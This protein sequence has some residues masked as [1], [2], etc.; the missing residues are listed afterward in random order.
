MGFPVG[1]PDGT[2]WAL[3]GRSEGSSGGLAAYDGTTW[4]LVPFDSDSDDP[5]ARWY[6]MAVDADSAVWVHGV[7]SGRATVLRWDGESWTSHRFKALPKFPTP[8][9][10]WPNDI[11]WFGLVPGH[12]DGT[13]LRAVDPSVPTG[14]SA[15]LVMASDG[16]AWTVIK[17]QLY[18]IT[19]EAVAAT[20]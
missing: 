5:D 12:W 11:V 9:Q 1:A 7:R 14:A 10:P 13:R 8:I 19:P 4:S 3:V 15:P 6:S 2:T 20:E 18:A 16:T 17:Q